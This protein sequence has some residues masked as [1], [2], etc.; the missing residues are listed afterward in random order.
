MKKITAEQEKVR[1]SAD[2]IRQFYKA[3]KNKSAM[4]VK[5]IK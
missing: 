4:I 1:L 2:M 3:W 5:K